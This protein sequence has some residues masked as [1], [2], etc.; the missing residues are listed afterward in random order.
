[1]TL[2]ELVINISVNAEDVKKGVA[3]ALAE[4]KKVGTSI[5]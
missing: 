5:A 2:D 3:A 1:M 4:I